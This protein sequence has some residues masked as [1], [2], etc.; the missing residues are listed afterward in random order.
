MQEAPVSQ[1]VIHQDQEDADGH[2][3]SAL[4]DHADQRQRRNPVI[5]TYQRR[6]WSMV[7]RVR[8]YYV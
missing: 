5:D 1:D 6:E 4:Q 2:E 8:P 7:C 3:A